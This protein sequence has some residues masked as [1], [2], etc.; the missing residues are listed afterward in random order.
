MIP[1]S[2][3]LGGLNFHT[4]IV[5]SIDDTGLGRAYNSLGLIKLAQYLH[6]RPIPQDSK[7]R[8]FYHE[9]V[10]AILDELGQ[11]ELSNNETFVDSF[12]S[13]LYQFEVTK[14]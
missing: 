13:L 3:T 5:E 12:S 9:L 11:K 2:F 10:H 14:K 1:N 4:E 6:G 7:E 8:T